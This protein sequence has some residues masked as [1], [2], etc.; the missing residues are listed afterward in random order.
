MKELWLLYEDGD[1]AV[2]RAYA[3]MM[4]ERGHTYGFDVQAVLLSELALGMD[5][6]GLPFC[7]CRGVSSLPHA[8]LSRQRSSLV[9]EHFERMGIP[10]FND[11]FVCAIC[12]DKRAT[13]QFLEG[14][15]MPR[16][17]F[18]LPSQMQPPA[19]TRYPVILKPACSHGGDRVTL[20][21][22]E[23]QWRKAAASIPDANIARRSAAVKVRSYRTSATVIL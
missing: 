12:N 20:V 6:Q 21:E 1:Y 5:A 14:L 15:P 19:G 3:Q 7:L 23:A 17:V 4:Q 10:V 8:V 18:L 9:S 11:S 16:T 13:Y 2:N 22:D